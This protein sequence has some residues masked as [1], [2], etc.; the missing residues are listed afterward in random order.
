MM[1]HPRYR[2]KQDGLLPTPSSIFPGVPTMQNQIGNLGH[3]PPFLG[4]KRPNALLLSPMLGKK[5]NQLLLQMPPINHMH[6]QKP[7]KRNVP[8]KFQPRIVRI[9]HSEDSNFPNQLLENN[10]NDKQESTSETGSNKQAGGFDDDDMEEA[11]R[12]HREKL[13][14]SVRKRKLQ[15]STDVK[16]HQID[17]EDYFSKDP[18]YSEPDKQE[19]T[20]DL[21]QLANYL[22]QMKGQ[23]SDSETDTPSN[24][25][26]VVQ[27]TR[28]VIAIN[29]PVA[30]QEN[31]KSFLEDPSKFVQN[32]TLTE[33]DHQV[34]QEIIDDD[35]LENSSF[36]KEKRPKLITDSD[37]NNTAKESVAS[38]D[39]DSD[40]FN[41]K[42]KFSKGD[43]AFIISS[44]SESGKLNKSAKFS[45]DAVPHPSSSSRNLFVDLTISEDDT[46]SKCPVESQP[47]S[48][49]EAA[50]CLRHVEKRDGSIEEDNLLITTHF[51][52]DK[53]NV[54]NLTIVKTEISS[55]RAP[56]K[57]SSWF[58]TACEKLVFE[59]KKV[60]Y[61]DEEHKA[62]KLLHR[63]H[64]LVC[65]VWFRRPRQLIQHMKSAEHKEKANVKHASIKMEESPDPFPEE[66]EENQAEHTNKT[67]ENQYQE[68]VEED[69]TSF[70]SS[71][72]HAKDQKYIIPVAGF[73][74]DICCDF[75]FDE[76]STLDHCETNEHCARVKEVELESNNRSAETVQSPEDFNNEEESQEL[77]PQSKSGKKKKGKKMSRRNSSNVKQEAFSSGLEQ[78]TFTTALK[79]K[80]GRK[81]SK[82]SKKPFDWNFIIP[83]RK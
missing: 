45:N 29:Q 19:D 62:K 27:D 23:K 43:S 20:K 5:R 40:L 79:Q 48:D 22:L 74:C 38:Y 76:A 10:L 47:T 56:Y 68:E 33:K 15:A 66:G 41:K 51:S 11:Y 46:T 81:T 60:H 16:Q 25:D 80:A 39:A 14:K 44:D 67:T 42:R 18:S 2:F 28:E 30:S 55:S 52:E 4:T 73:Y 59:E 53:I 70:D 24:A 83:K 61:R 9:D 32:S 69:T 37:I 7:Q 63:P 82:N 34:E 65:D 8:A 58:C 78:E 57:T 31:K 1:S 6:R 12:L 77:P 71:K 75:F 35:F 21:S 13:S 54:E 26:V 50:S 72:K 49:K 36:L 17:A 3:R 64:C